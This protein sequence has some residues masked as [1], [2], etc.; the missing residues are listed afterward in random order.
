MAKKKKAEEHENLERWL[1]S[2]ADFMTLLFATFVVLYALAQ[3]DVDAFKNMADAL[4][5]AF[6]QSFL[7]SQNK[8]M[9]GADSLLDG[10]SGATNPV[11]LE[12]V[13]NKYEQSSYESIE[14]EVN[15]LKQDGLSAAIDDR[16]L[17][18]KFD[19][20][21][22]KFK[23]ASAEISTSSYDILDKVAEIIKEKFSIHFIEVDGHTDSDKTGPNAKYPSNWELSSARASSVVRYLINKHNFNPRLFSAVGYSDTVPVVPNATR[24]NKA[25]NR[26]VEIVVLKNK[27]KNLIKKDMETILKEAKAMQRAYKGKSG[28]GPS[29]AMKELVGND[30][31]LLENVIDMSGEYKNEVKRLNDLNHDDYIMDG[32]KPAFME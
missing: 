27:N 2:Y 32:N 8:I 26:R 3:S 19:K 28:S 7:S 18:I 29:D 30:K 23:P 10:R 12:Y 13:S 1:V 14:K 25:K 15:S 17:V 20:D 4:R 16:G 5:D 24:E 22:I 11:M 6:D 9:N 21:A 31:Q